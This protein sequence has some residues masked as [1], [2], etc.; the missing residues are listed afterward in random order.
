MDL[1][2]RTL[3]LGREVT[4]GVM[5]LV[6][7]LL[8]VLATSVPLEVLSNPSAAWDLILYLNPLANGLLSI[9]SCVNSMF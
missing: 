4:F 3:V 9:F 1:S 6:G 2:G 7:V 5:T 8:A